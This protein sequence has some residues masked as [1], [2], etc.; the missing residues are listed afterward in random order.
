[1]E[2]EYIIR[3]DRMDNNISKESCVVGRDDGFLPVLHTNISTLRL[4]LA[5]VILEG[6]RKDALIRRKLEETQW[7]YLRVLCSRT[8][9]VPLLDGLIKFVGVV[10]WLVISRHH[11]FLWRR[12]S[13]AS[14]VM[15]GHSITAGFTVIL[16]CCLSA[17][18]G[19]WRAVGRRVDVGDPTRNLFCLGSP[20][21][22]PFFYVGSPLP[23]MSALK[24]LPLLF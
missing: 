9:P 16:S 7:F 22:V 18:A 1:M 20:L 5:S 11:R 3:S 13:T 14:S 15:G 8:F 19:V 23:G 21:V 6:V 4:I 12:R 17:L 10:L 24:F 2:S